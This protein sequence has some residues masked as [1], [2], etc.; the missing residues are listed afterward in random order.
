MCDLV[1][2][3]DDVETDCLKAAPQAID[4]CD[5][6]LSQLF[7]VAGGKDGRDFD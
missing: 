5:E 1:G 6:I 2:C 3:D 4:N 7:R